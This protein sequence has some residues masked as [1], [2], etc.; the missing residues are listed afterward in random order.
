MDWV[1][2]FLGLSGFC[3]YWSSHPFCANL[4]R[5]AVWR[6]IAAAGRMMPRKLRQFSSNGAIFE[7]ARRPP[8]GHKLPIRVVTGIHVRRT[9]RGSDTTFATQGFRGL[10]HA[11]VLGLFR[12][13]WINET[14]SASK[15]AF[16]L[17][18][19]GCRQDLQGRRQGVY[20][21]A[22]S[23]PR[24]L[25]PYLRRAWVADLWKNGYGWPNCGALRRF[26]ERYLT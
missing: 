23:R 9:N 24:P 22:S 8:P 15:W 14:C 6:Q 17:C 21:C 11:E 1:V 19:I 16:S 13:G 26:G 2:L 18:K 25:G 20:D 4:T 3:N 10:P 12:S 7:L 5:L